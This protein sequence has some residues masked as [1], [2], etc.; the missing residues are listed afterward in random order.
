MKRKI[1]SFAALVLSCLMA[2]PVLADQLSVTGLGEAVT[3][4]KADT[5]YMI[6]GNGQAQQIS[7]LYDNNGTF[8]ATASADAPTGPEAMAY[9]WTFEITDD[10]YAAKEFRRHVY[11]HGL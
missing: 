5:R 1:T 3:A 8:A 7:W 6:Q 11:R 9:V 4:P 10:G 2:A